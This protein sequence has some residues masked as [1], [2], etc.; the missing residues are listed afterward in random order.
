MQEL[1]EQYRA[2]G[3]MVITL[4]T[5]NGMSEPPTQS[6]LDSWAMQYGQTFP[7]LS[8]GDWLANRFSRRG[9]T[10]SLPSIS[11]LGIGAEV[12]IADGDPEASDIEQ[13]LP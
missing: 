2:Q 10:V 5:E 12:L 7:V 9:G 4:I 13:A 6:D 11:L 1:Y 8:D 3:L